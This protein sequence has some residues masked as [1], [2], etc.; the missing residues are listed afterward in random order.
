MRNHFDTTPGRDS[1]KERIFVSYYATCYKSAVTVTLFKH[2]P[3]SLLNAY[4]LKD[5]Y[6]VIYSIL[7]YVTILIYILVVLYY[8]LPIC[9]FTVL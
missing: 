1:Q 9:K 8:G 4:F 7:R 2:L 3:R 5:M 6:I